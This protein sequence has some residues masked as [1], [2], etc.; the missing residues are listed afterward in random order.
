MAQ[1]EYRLRPGICFEG[2]RKNMNN[3][4]KQTVSRFR[5]ELR[6]CCMHVHSVTLT[7]TSLCNAHTQFV[8]ARFLKELMSDNNKNL[9]MGHQGRLAD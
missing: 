2:L 7:L 4:R 1:A 8:G 9:V 6:P 5:F 3:L